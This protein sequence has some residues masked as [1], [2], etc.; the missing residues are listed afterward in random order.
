MEW[1]LWVFLSATA[2]ICA[3]LWRWQW[4]SRR[5]TNDLTAV[6]LTE[7]PGFLTPDECDA[8]V[9]WIRAHPEK[10]SESKVDRP[11][12]QQ[13]MNAHRRSEQCWLA[14]SQHRGVLDLRRRAEPILKGYLQT[15][16]YGF[17]CLQVVRYKIGGFFRPHYDEQVHFWRKKYGRDATLLIYLNDNFT[18]GETVF[19]RLGRTI[20]PQ[21]GKAILFRNLHPKSRT[22]LRSAYHG[23]LP[24]VSGE[25]YILNFW[26]HKVE[27]E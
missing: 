18:G 10:F 1:P 13:V 9:E 2:C 12:G 11:F 7:V 5:G 8:W 17:E 19:P 27:N 23:G 6:D 4:Q 3:G 24:V 21:K 20:I 25:K 22:F 15:G 14:P 26:I 16:L